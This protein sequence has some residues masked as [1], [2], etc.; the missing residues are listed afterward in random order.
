MTP[1]IEATIAKIPSRA[2]PRHHHH[3]WTWPYASTKRTRRKSSVAR[4][5]YYIHGPYVVVGKDLHHAAMAYLA[6]YYDAGEI[7]TYLQVLSKLK[8]SHA[9][10]IFDVSAWRESWA[11]MGLRDG[12]LA[13]DSE[14]DPS[15]ETHPAS[16]YELQLNRRSLRS[17]PLTFPLF[18]ARSSN[19]CGRIALHSA[20]CRGEP[21]R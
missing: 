19:R 16:F 5:E 15:T 6:P 3:R 9:Q 8:N 21:K 4:W 17:A 12:L 13:L 10:P 1:T 18:L 2:L 20:C 7:L 14:S 11:R